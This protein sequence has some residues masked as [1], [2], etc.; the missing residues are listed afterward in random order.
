MPGA[1]RCRGVGLGLFLVVAGTG[2]ATPRA[3]AAQDFGTQSP[4]TW[5]REI[6]LEE[7][8]AVI[9]V[10]P[11]VPAV[12][13]LASSSERVA[14]RSTGVCARSWNPCCIMG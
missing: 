5:I 13:L 10:A 3:L 9:N 2:H 11:V 4:A 12:S 1:V 8:P 14:G 6:R 7:S